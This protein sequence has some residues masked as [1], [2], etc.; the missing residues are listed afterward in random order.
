MKKQNW[1]KNTTKGKNKD[2]NKTKDTTLK[3]FLIT[4]LLSN[5]TLGKDSL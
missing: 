4:E 3:L 5:M 1:K 2:T